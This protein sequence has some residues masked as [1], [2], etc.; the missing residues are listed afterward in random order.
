MSAKLVKQKPSAAPLNSGNPL[1]GRQRES[2]GWLTARPQSGPTLVS[3]PMAKHQLFVI[4]LIP[5]LIPAVQ[6]LASVR[7]PHS[8][9]QTVIEAG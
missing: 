8:T 6:V 1:R 4:L 2:L 5:L 9:S 7:N 3:D